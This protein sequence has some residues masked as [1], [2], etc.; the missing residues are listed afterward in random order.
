MVWASLLEEPLN[1]VCGWPHLALT[2]TCGNHNVHH[3]RVARFL[4]IPTIFIGRAYD[5]LKT[6]LA[7]LLATL[8]ALLLFLDSDVRRCLLAAA[9][10]HPL[11]T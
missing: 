10:G 9:W 1:V 11:A 6:L 3:T 2:A 4:T 7:P 8:G 5:L